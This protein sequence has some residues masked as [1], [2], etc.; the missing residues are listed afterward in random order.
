MSDDYAIDWKAYK[1]ELRPIKVEIMNG[2]QCPDHG[3]ICSCIPPELK[4]IEE[5]LRRKHI[6]K[7]NPYLY[8]PHIAKPLV[9]PEGYEYG[10]KTFRSREDLNAL[11]THGWHPVGYLDPKWEIRKDMDGYYTAGCA[12][13]CERIKPVEA[14]PLESFSR[15]ELNA[16][17]LTRCDIGMAEK[18][19]EELWQDY[20]ERKN[21]TKEHACTH[22]AERV[23]AQY[24]KLK[25]EVT[26]VLLKPVFTVTRRQKRKPTIEEMLPALQADSVMGTGVTRADHEL[27][28]KAAM[29][30]IVDISDRAESLEPWEK[31]IWKPIMDSMDANLAAIERLEKLGFKVTHERTD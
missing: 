23:H 11:Y 30:R 28:W 16:E 3:Y 5:E 8:L 4:R 14:E 7:Q 12:L 10:W 31:A 26:L 21:L 29:D 19:A 24:P 27:A 22:V 25:C 20:S 9:A 6:K 1:E 2:Y 13:L 18:Y 17:V 15:D